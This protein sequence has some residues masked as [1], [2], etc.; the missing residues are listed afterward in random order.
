MLDY[1][2]KIMEKV[3]EINSYINLNRMLELRKQN[4]ISSIHS[5][6]AIENN[7]LSLFQVQDVING[8]VVIGDRTDIQEVKNAY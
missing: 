7:Q 3:G 1:I 2:S 8:R 5:S 4:R 6:L